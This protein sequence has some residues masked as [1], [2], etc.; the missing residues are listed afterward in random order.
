[1]EAAER[2]PRG[3]RE[4]ERGTEPLAKNEGRIEDDKATA[5]GEGSQTRAE[6]KMSPEEEC[7][8]D[9]RLL[10]RMHKLEKDVHYWQDKVDA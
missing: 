1:M 5:S 3:P 10:N 8:L 4:N 2:E 9:H 7:E 6:S